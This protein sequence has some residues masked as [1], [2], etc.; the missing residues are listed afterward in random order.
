VHG[1]HTQ[2]VVEGLESVPGIPA[3]ASGPAGAGF[4]SQHPW[5][6]LWWVEDDVDLCQ[7]LTPRLR[8]CGWGLQSFSQPDPMLAALRRQRPDLLILDQVL[9]G[10]LGSAL[11]QQLRSQGH[12]FPVLMLSGCGRAVDRVVGLE[13]GAQDYLAKPFLFK[14]LALRCEQLLRVAS[15]SP[16][17]PYSHEQALVL[18]PVTFW[19][20]LGTLRLDQEP[21]VSL[22]RGESSLL[23]A[24][25]RSP[26]RVL[27]RAQLAQAAGS[28]VNSGSSRSIDV[29]LGRLRRLLE[30]TSN[31]VLTIESVRAQGYAL[32]IASAK[33]AAAGAE[34]E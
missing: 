17:A 11:L 12:S 16:V 18:G 8:A 10:C 24:L 32:R 2:I 5:A 20:R 30:C 31:G 3:D 25:A 29:R 26:G 33:P 15:L 4:R 13:S 23:L 27:S 21:V 19:P 6:Q 28:L 1:G 7:A 14:E 34:A 9:P 22:S